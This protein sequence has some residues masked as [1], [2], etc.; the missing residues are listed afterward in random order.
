[1]DFDHPP[2]DPVEACKQWLIEA[3]SLGLM[4][5]NAFT[6]STVSGEGRPNSR[7]ILLK[8][9]D[10][11]GAVFYTNRLSRKGR[12]LQD[13]PRVSLLFY[14]DKFARQ[15][16]IDGTISL[17]S[18]EES[19]AY[20][21]TRPRG[22]QIGAWASKQSEPIATRAELDAA[23]AAVE[24]QYEGDTVP[25]PPHWGGYRV[26][27][28]TIEIWQGQESRLHDRVEYRADGNGGWTIQR[29]NP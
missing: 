18:D 11:R 25:R 14:W 4:N 15:I 6:L 17:V 19:D 26:S 23:F 7:V 28:E 8:D 13:N 5:P 2:A 16:R 3:E 1:M 29:L 24:K 12:E 22:S 27:L 9:I 21:A 20:F 10:T